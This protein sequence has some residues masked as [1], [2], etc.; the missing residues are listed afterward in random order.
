MDEN[1]DMKRELKNMES[2]MDELQDNFREEQAD[3]YVSVKK[4]LEQTTK[5]CRILSFKLKK[6]ERKIEQLETEAQAKG[7]QSNSEMAT[8]IKQ[9]EDELRVANEVARR[10]QIE[11]EKNESNSK[12]PPNLGKIGK[13]N[14][15]SG[16][17]FSRASLTRGGSQEDPAQL[18]RDLQDSAEREAD[19]REQLRFAEEEVS[20]AYNIHTVYL[21]MSLF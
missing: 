6:S 14:S 9:L 16:S 15:D 7:N 17:K 8:R 4:E 3:E 20:L 13:S 21:T 12:K 19:L 11:S 5:N 10:L 1:E 2:E 18:L